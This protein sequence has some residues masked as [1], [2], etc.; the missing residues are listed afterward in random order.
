MSF[1]YLALLGLASSVSCALTAPKF[2][3]HEGLVKSVERPLRAEICLNGLWQFQ[4]IAMPAGHRRGESPV[5]QLPAPNPTA[6]EATPIKIPS[7]WN[8][9]QWGP[10][11]R[12]EEVGEGTARPYQPDS[13]Y[14][15]SYPRAWDHVQMGWLRR[16]FQIPAEWKDKRLLLHFEAVAGGFEVLVNGTQAGEHFDSHLPAE[17]DITA[18]VRPGAENEL[19]VGVRHPSLFERKSTRYPKF[20][21]PFPP[22][23]MTDRLVGIWQDVFL[24]ALPP[25]RVA[26]VFVQPNLEK[27]HLDVVAT[28]RNDTEQPQSIELGGMVHPWS[29]ATPE[30]SWRLGDVVLALPGRFVQLAPRA[31]VEVV[32][33]VQPQGRLRTWS[34]DAPNLYG[35]VLSVRAGDA[36]L[37]TRYER[38][39]W[40]QL[41][42]HGSEVRLNGRPIK[43]LG[44]FCHPFGPF[45][46][47]R[48]FAWAW[49]RMIKDVGGNLLRPHAQPYPRYYLDVADEM[50]ILLLDET[51]VFGSSI[52]LNPEVPEFWTRYAEHYE[53]LIRRDRNHPCVFGWSFGNEMF[54]IPMLNKMSSADT[55]E[56][57]DKL[58]AVGLRGRELDPTRA[59]LSCDGDEDLQGKLPVWS[60][61]HGLA[62]STIPD[63][64]KPQMIGESGGTYYAT[65]KQLSVFNG[66]R[67]YESYLGRNEA[68][69]IDLYENVVQLALPK[70]A[71]YSPSEM[72]WFGLE[73]L[74]LGKR[75]LSR[76]PAL[77]EG[78]F[79]GPFAE[80]QPGMQPERL[81]P[82][83]GTLNPGWDPDLPLYRPLPMFH[84]MKAALA[85][86]GPRPCPWDHRPAATAPVEPAPQPTITR[87]AFC[88]DRGGKLAARLVAWG[89]PLVADEQA[90]MIIVDTET[91]APVQAR[92]ALEA[93]RTGG[94]T[95]L[96]MASS[97]LPA[98]LLPVE[99][100]WTERVATA[101][102][103]D[104]EH[105]W[106]RTFTLPQLYFAE[107]GASRFIL[108]HGTAG[109]FVHQGRVLLQASNT[110]W[111][112]FN[113][114]PEV[115]KAGAI[116]LHEQLR[117]PGGAALVEHPHGKGTIVLSTLE[118]QVADA[119]WQTLLRH[120]GLV[121][122]QTRPQVTVAFDDAGALVHALSIGRFGAA[123]LDAA[124]RTDFLGGVTPRRGVKAGRCAWAPV[125]SPSKDRFV[126]HQMKQADPSAAFAVYFSCWLKS[127]RAL[128]DLLLAGPDVPRLNLFCYVSE[129][130][131]VFLNGQELNPGRT[132]PADYRR[133]LAFDGLPLKKGWNHLLLKVA[134]TRLEGADPATLAVRIQSTNAEF[135]RQ[136]ES[137]AEL[138]ASETTSSATAQAPA[139]KHA[140]DRPNVLLVFSDQHNADVLG[141]AGH[142]IVKT[143]NLDA[144]ARQGV[145]FT[146]AY[147]QDA[148]CVPSRVSV[149]TGLYPRTT[150]CLTNG[151]EKLLDN[152]GDLCP[153]HQVLQDNGYFTGF[154]GK[155]HLGIGALIRGWDHS[156]TVL[157]LRAEPSEESYFD[158][159]KSQG[160]EAEF[161]HDWEGGNKSDL[162][163]HI[164]T[165]PP[166][167]RDA[168]Y[169]AQK[170]GE[171]LRAAA[172]QGKPFFC[173]TSF[174]GPHQ[175]YAPPQR[176][177]DL[178]PPESI[179]LP[180]SV[181][182]PAENL[183]PGLQDWR[184][185]ERKPWNLAKAAREP[186]L[187]QRYI[188]AYY[189]QVSEVDHYIGEVLAQLDALG[190][191]D[192]TIVIYTSDHGDFVGRHGMVEKCSVGHNVYEETLRV[193][194]IVSWPKRF[195]RG[196]TCDSLAELVDLYPTVA[197]L[198]HLKRPAGAPALAGRPLAPTLA[199]GKPT[200]RR[201][202]FSE[203][204]SQSTVISE[205][206]K[207][208]V[209][210]DPG[211]KH[212]AWDW[213]GKTRDQLYDRERDPQEL[214]NLA[215]TPAVADIEKELRQA[216]TAHMRSNNPDE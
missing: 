5:P 135:F 13:E 123:D 134:S 101:L 91:A 148:I 88:G 203:N 43:M 193:P 128:D 106:T 100:Q 65:P 77:S 69:A 58:V 195:Q 212:K 84:A 53:R 114:V 122:N 62:V 215:G 47:S 19:L 30:S 113:N 64:G 59:W 15:P 23:S 176:W 187:Y 160:K 205:R 165:L 28:V 26:E 167:L 27:D 67:A 80:D 42:I 60:K 156:V 151:D 164:S 117:K 144:L 184:R 116:V 173:W 181:N 192:N 48:R 34:P 9:N 3:P 10:G 63:V 131:R 40:R 90:A 105:P 12:G 178:Y 95:A 196:A 163:T 41:T 17:F 177:A 207:L 66:D 110:D 169:T 86:G 142:P 4:P 210:T 194:L 83:C 129:R 190:L 68:M 191:R 159:I 111:S 46:M 29:G 107:D 120:M 49:C 82:Y 1:S 85:K 138:P 140:T 74:P 121:L 103:P 139:A 170:A 112:L 16:T 79:F 209:W 185:N 21:K 174:H 152:R 166:E 32:L 108:R 200:G 24:R 35:L 214:R 206:Y 78:V 213:R 211:P 36:P 20:L 141:C 201:Y 104:R 33:G 72:V 150:G 87:V 14:Y 31:S 119:F 97:R 61:H 51:A 22:G 208:G 197:A 2:A 133:R 136:L 180:E 8:V 183:P 130:C 154:F 39:G 37:D 127:P 125:D 45:M 146:R 202:A 7:P 93:I 171:F 126:F 162:C 25:V 204:Y 198:L 137:A 149:V 143:P 155:L 172:T 153:L 76:V 99:A 18:L 132:E 54:A 175:P 182:E 161:L 71:A 73:H 98:G 52:C 157:P 89:V 96:V 124:L 189:A 158:W 44:D 102:V 216:L 115:V 188:A 38:F 50:G 168:A 70:L 145:R 55:A 81:P 56:Y 11:R 199:E 179:P 75:D 186:I 109:P 6:W 147:C 118:T 94:G 57:Y 92:R